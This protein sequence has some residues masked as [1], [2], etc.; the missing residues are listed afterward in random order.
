MRR[1]KLRAGV[2]VV[3][4]ALV[5]GGCNFS[6][7]APDDSAVTS[8]IQA[9]LFQDPVLKTR[10]IQVNTQSGVVTLSGTVNTE[11]EKAAAERLASQETGV[12]QVIDQ[13]A[14]A[15][16]A[17]AQAA[18]AAA[19]ATEQAVTEPAPR[20]KKPRRK[21]HATEMA[22]NTPPP[23]AQ[24]AQNQPPA[25]APVV[26]QSPQ[27]A[28]PPPPPPPVTITIPAGTAVRV[29]MIDTVDSSVNQPGQEFS[30][31]VA[32]PVVVGS[33]VVI[34]ANSDAKVRLVNAKSS[35]RMEGSAQLALELDSLTVNGTA[36]NVESSTFQQSGSS[37]GRRTAEATGA[38][39]VL[40]GLIGAIAGRGKGAAIGAGAGAATG[41]GVEAASGRGQ[42]KVPS[43]TKID[44]TLKA[45]LNVT[46]SQ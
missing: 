7:K 9:K 26:D 44:F 32:A 43:E 22:L 23:A 46:L 40:G 3:V 24:P 18:P 1:P 39:A 12:K 35:G 16:S 41:A 21:Q 10:D 37:R 27:P 31:T 8:G 28:A 45:P 11:L 2:L 25:P 15:N 36:Y 5:A 19:P 13:L 42:V 33:Q 17:A 20:T 38:G 30:A 4:L 14:V 6:K 34:P 29:E